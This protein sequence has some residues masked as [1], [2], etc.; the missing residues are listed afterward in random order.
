MTPN[1]PE[2]RNMS[3]VNRPM[4]WGKVYVNKIEEEDRNTTIIVASLDRISFRCFRFS[5]DQLAIDC[6]QHIVK[7]LS[8]VA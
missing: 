6:Y 3:N 1:E 8:N 5:K 7:E 2:D 4:Q